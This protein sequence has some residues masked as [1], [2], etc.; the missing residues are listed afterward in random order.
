MD[1]KRRSRKVMVARGEPTSWPRAREET[2]DAVTLAQSLTELLIPRLPHLRDETQSPVVVVKGSTQMSDPMLARARRVWDLLRPRAEA[3]AALQD[4]VAIVAA[5]PDDADAHAALRLQLRRALEADP[6]LRDELSR[7]LNEAR[8]SGSDAVAVDGRSV[9][10]KG[11]VFGKQIGGGEWT[12]IG[13]NIRATTE[14]H[15][16][17]RKD[18]RS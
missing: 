11:V 10:I 6:R 9:A 2:V 17:I 1:W 18:Q 3:N 4:A 13:S 12:N 8:V 14:G 5:T 15:N 7:V 16:P